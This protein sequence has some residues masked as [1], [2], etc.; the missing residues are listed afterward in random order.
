M[1]VVLSQLLD[2]CQN[3]P[4]KG[5]NKKETFVVESVSARNKNKTK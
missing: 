5:R 4:G 3:R 2:Q 1:R